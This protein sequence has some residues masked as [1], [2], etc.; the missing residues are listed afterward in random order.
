MTTGTYKGSIYKK[1]IRI[2]FFITSVTIFIGY[3]IAIG[4]YMKAEKQ[5]ALHLKNEIV[6]VIA[7][8]LAKLTFLKTVTS[9]ADI[10]AKLK[11]F[12]NLQAVVVYAKGK[13][14]IYEYSKRE[15]NVAMPKQ[16]INKHITTKDSTLFISSDIFYYGKKI[17]CATVA[18]KFKTIFSII[19]ENFMGML[20]FYLLMLFFS[21]VLASYYAKKFTEPVLY[22]T[23]F[24]EEIEFT[25][26]LKKRIPVKYDDEFGKL[27]EETNI[28]LENIEKSLLLEEKAQKDLEYLQQYDPLTGFA[29]KNLLLKSLQ[30]RIEKKEKKDWHF[31][32]C[33]NIKKFNQVNDLHGHTVGD[34]ILQKL[35][36]QLKSDFAGATILAKIGVDEF[37]ICYRNIADRKE[38]V[39]PK[40]EKVID[41]LKSK[42]Y[43]ELT[44]DNKVINISL[45]VGINIYEDK[46][47]TAENILRQ[48]DAALHLAK[49]Q[50]KKFAFYDKE[51]E[52]E[53]HNHLEIAS[54]LFRAIKDKEFELYYQLQY[55]DDESVY[56]AEALIRWNHPTKG[57]IP[58]IKFIEIAENSGSIVAIGEWVIK[59]ACRQLALWENSERTKEWVIAINVSS[60]QF[61]EHLI[62]KIKEA[63]TENSI[64]PQKLKVELT[65]S[66]FLENFDTNVQKLQELR[67]FGIQISIDDFGTGYSSLQYLKKL[68][69]NQVKIDQSFVFGML[70][71]NKDVAIIKSIIQL[72][73]ALELDIIA[74]GVETEEHFSLLKS[75]HCKYFQG[76]YFAK[77][78]PVEKIEV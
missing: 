40:A 13:S 18:L 47:N 10:T 28:M 21:L 45:Y 78:Q 9:A 31:M 72:G 17:G 16:C 4:L 63:V 32:F 75:L 56:G 25:S 76:Y 24:L 12:E 51:I 70:D 30:N 71:N 6:E 58:P 23:N 34:I 57:I 35:A 68:P 61:D 36:N 54:D 1:L 53:M 44:I 22:L 37:I 38:Q 55:K 62:D 41:I 69:I 42:R 3:A 65:E 48:T 74:E 52:N 43:Q 60:K 33:L 66:L 27:Y 7:Q 29:K 46:N 19:K 64:N 67:D 2:I 15:R 26:S 11:A 77:P 39:I 20:S 59:E 8:D 73:E 14:A 50:D 49:E 5:N